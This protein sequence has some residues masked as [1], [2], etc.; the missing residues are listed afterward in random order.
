MHE[1]GC[2][3][4]FSKSHDSHS[5]SVMCPARFKCLTSVWEIGVRYCCLHILNRGQ[6]TYQ[7][8][9]LQ[10]DN[11][12]WSAEIELK[13]SFTGHFAVNCSSNIS[14]LITKLWCLTQN[15]CD[16][17]SVPVSVRESCVQ[18]RVQIIS[19]SLI[20]YLYIFGVRTWQLTHQ[21]PRL[22]MLGTIRLFPIHLHGEMLNH[23]RQKV[24]WFVINI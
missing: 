18:H 5:V 14:G 10:S 3:V 11:F 20:I 16:R 6:P 24:T 8:M 7:D 4:V 9:S 19:Y 17:N 21:L 12:V 13:A 2:H 23:Y 15:N 1:T 22:T